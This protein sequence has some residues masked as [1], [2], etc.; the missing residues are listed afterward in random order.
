MHDCSE[1]ANPNPP[2][3]GLGCLPAVLGV[4]PAQQGHPETV[5]AL[6]LKH[7]ERNRMR[8]A[9]MLT[10]KN[11]CI[12]KS[13]L[14]REGKVP[15][16]RQQFSPGSR[17]GAAM[18]S[19]PVPVAAAAFRRGSI[20]QQQNTA[21]ISCCAGIGDPSMNRARGEIGGQAVGLGRCHRPSMPSSPLVLCCLVTLRSKL[22]AMPPRRSQREHG[23]KAS[24]TSLLSLPDD[25]LLRCLGLL[26]QQE[27]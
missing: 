6:A 20:T 11:G 4:V 1:K 12:C 19:G 2:S 3:D 25:L 14:E 17:P 23:G 18:W 24:P 13:C 15:S 22:V 27:R 9:P 8:S 5:P 26:S 10:R 16:S 21:R 7:E